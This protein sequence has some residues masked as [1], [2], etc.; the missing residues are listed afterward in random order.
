MEPTS[1]T[2]AAN[3]TNSAQTC[4]GT[5]AGNVPEL[6]AA[7]EIDWAGPFTEADFQPFG[8]QDRML[9]QDLANRR[10]VQLMKMLPRVWSV[11]PDNFHWTVNEIPGRATGRIIISPKKPSTPKP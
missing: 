8:R 6:P 5:G 7:P 11:F 10:W 9:I 3:A 4:T 1:Q 2:D